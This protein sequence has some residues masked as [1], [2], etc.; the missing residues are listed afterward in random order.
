MRLDAAHREAQRLVELMA[1]YCERI[2][3]AGSI[4]RGK[5]EVKDIELVALPKLGEVTL[6]GSLWPEEVSLLHA[7]ALSNGPAGAGVH[8]IKTGTSVLEPWK[9]SIEARYLRG[10]L[11]MTL[12][13][14][15]QIHSGTLDLFVC[16]GWT[17]GYILALRTGSAEFSR[18]LVTH[19]REIGCRCEGGQVLG[20]D[21]RAI[22]VPE[23]KDFFD[24]LGIEW[25][26]PHKRTGPEA[27]RSKPRRA[28]A[29]AR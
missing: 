1:P 29:K 28:L 8:W 17:W 23:E 20:P 11:P 27:L 19:A 16:E 22:A 2:A 5:P 15:K 18:A 3:I 9:P 10:A 7:W 26:E 6:P 12:Y 25:I 21:G 24:T 4:R 14:Q 13:Y